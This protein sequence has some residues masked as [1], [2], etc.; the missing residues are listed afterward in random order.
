MCRHSD[1]GCAFWND[2]RERNELMNR[3][4]QVAACVALAMLT[5]SAVHSETAPISPPGAVPFDL[6]NPQVQE[7]ARK[8]ARQPPV[9]P[10]RGHHLVDDHSGRRQAGR[11]SV[12]SSKFQ[13]RRMA[14]G[15]RFNHAGDAAASKTLP[16]GTV[17]KVTNLEN[18]RTAVVTVEDH[19]PYV[20]GRTI[21]LTKT[22][23]EQIGIGAHEGVAPVVVAPIAV[24][25]PDGTIKPGAGALPGPVSAP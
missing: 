20:D 18:G 11:A 22:T 9:L 6:N 10:P 12:Y 1:T 17:A 19:G 14:N 3:C 23:S 13:G 5:L 16:L 7:E 24:P 15:R 4:G 2:N 21:D 8:L 25:Q